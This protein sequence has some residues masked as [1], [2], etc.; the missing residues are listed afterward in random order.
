MKKLRFRSLLTYSILIFLIY[1][2]GKFFFDRRILPIFI[3]L[4][5]IVAWEANFLRKIKDYSFFKKRVIIFSNIVTVCFLIAIAQIFRIQI[6]NYDKFKKMAEKQSQGTVYEKGIRGKILADTGEELSYEIDIYDLAIDPV[7][8]LKLD[9]RLEIL[10]KIDKIKNI[11]LNKVRKKLTSLAKDNKRYYRIAK[12]IS[13]DEKG[14]IKDIIKTYNI[15]YNEIFF[16]RQGKRNYSNEEYF[17]HI[18]GYTGKGKDGQEIGAY[19]VERIYDSYLKGKIVEKKAYYTGARGLKLPI[20]NQITPLEYKDGKNAVLTIDYNIQYILNEELR[21][22]FIKTKAKTASGMVMDPKTGKILAMASLPYTKLRY[23]RNN[24]IHNQYE[25]GSIM[26]PVIVAAEMDDGVINKNTNFY[27]EGQ[28]VKHRKVIR[29]SHKYIGNM[30]TEDIVLNSS[31]IGMV[32]IADLVEDSRFEEY[33]KNFGFYDRT[34][35]DLSGELK[36]R[37]L[38]YEKWN[39]LKKSTMSFGQGIALT[40]LQM[41]NAFAA[42]INGGKLYRPYI[43]DRIED[44]NG[45]IVRQNIPVVMQDVISESTSDKMR[46]ILE[47]VVLDGTGKSAG[48]EGYRIGGKTGTA[49]ISGKGGYIAREYLSSFI[50]FFPVQEPQYLILIMLEKPQAKYTYLKYGG[51]TAAPVFKEVAKRIIAYKNLLPSQ[52]GELG[53][54]KI[55]EAQGEDKTYYGEYMP[56]L[57]G[58]TL[59]DALRILGKMD[60]E[61]EVAGKGVIVKQYP[62]VGSDMGSVRKIKLKLGEK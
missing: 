36:P 25:P 54:V 32:M 61:I 40:P 27:N 13:E 15:R 52:V 14:K 50:G 46:K 33:L 53:D 31:N 11:D 48:I 56:N 2:L 24:L 20:F 10:D 60:V 59:K 4:A 44:S 8:F 51:W 57:R 41:T 9:E 28:I 45:V 22:Q 30:T 1:R 39:G 42:V 6:L 19:G 16:R 34:G 5:L 7:R 37:Q 58:K 49:Q 12:G 21:K 17:R 26:K 38:P 23:T 47:G 62:E 43:V 18:L 29:D 55:E 35:I 3:V